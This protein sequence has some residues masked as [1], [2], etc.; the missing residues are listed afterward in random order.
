MFKTSVRPRL[1]RPVPLFIETETGREDHTFR[2]TFEVA[3]MQ[4]S[5]VGPMGTEEGQQT[6]LRAS[7]KDLS[8]IQGDDGSET[9]FTQD[10]LSSL[11]TRIE[12]RAALLRAYF[13]AV[14]E[15]AAMAGAVPVAK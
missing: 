3:D 4:L 5:A 6:L 15:V 8:D 2:A 11:L 10:L 1:T 14:Q 7:I 13:D 12:C 9:P